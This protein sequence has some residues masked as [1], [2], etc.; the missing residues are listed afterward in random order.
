MKEKK[1]NQPKQKFNPY[2]LYAMVIVLLLSLSL[3]SDSSLQSV[4]KTNTFD[5]E[6]HLNSGDID[7]VLI[8]NEKI[9]IINKIEYSVPIKE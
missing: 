4:G 3:F 8:Q 2:W 7:R 9:L 1:K 5:F 6:R